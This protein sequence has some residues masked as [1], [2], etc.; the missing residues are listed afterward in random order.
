MLD[1]NQERIKSRA[2]STKI[3]AIYLTILVIIFGAILAGLVLDKLL[4]GTPRGGLEVNTKKVEALKSFMGTELLDLNE[5]I[6]RQLDISTTQGAL[7]NSVIDGSPADEAGMQRGDVIMQFDRQKV[8][9]TT[10]LQELIAETSPGDR[11]RV[12][13][14]R[15]KKTKAFYIKLEETPAAASPVSLTQAQPEEQ[16]PTQPGWGMGVAPISPDMGQ[17][18]GLQQGQEGILVTSIIPTGAA[19][20]AGI[21][22]GDVILAVNNQPTTG[23]SQFYEEIAGSQGVVLDIFRDEQS[24]Y[25]TV[26][27]NPSQLPTASLGM[28]TVLT[29]GSSEDDDEGYK[30]KPPVIPPK[31]EYDPETMGARTT[32][33]TL[34]SR[35]EVC[36]CPLCGTTVT[37]P[38]GT[39]CS[40]LKCP[41]CGSRLMNAS[42]GITTSFDD[43]RTPNQGDPQ[44]PSYAG[45]AKGQRDL[46]PTALSSILTGGGS[47]EDDDDEG[48]KPS[49]IPPMGNPGDAANVINIYQVAGKPISDQPS[50]IPSMG[51][52]TGGG[53]AVG[54]QTTAGTVN[55]VQVCICPVCGT[56]VGH[57]AGISCSD[58]NCPYCGSRMTSV[59]PG[60][61]FS[62]SQ[63]ETQQG[64][65]PPTAGQ[66]MA[67]G[68]SGGSSG[69]GNSS[70]GGPTADQGMAQGGTTGTQGMSQGSSSM[71]SS[72]YG[73]SGSGGPSGECVC[74][75]CGTLVSHAASVPCYAMKCPKC[76][77]PMVRAIP[78]VTIS[79][80]PETIP[81]TYK[82]QQTITTS[83]SISQKIAIASQGK[84]LSSKIAPL[85]DRSPYFV[86]VGL[87]ISEAFRNPNVNDSRDVGIQSAQFV[88]D[89]GA[90]AVITNNISLEA[91]Q[92]L[93]RLNIK[94]YS[95]VSGTVS[96]A[97]ECYMDGHLTETTLGTENSGSGSHE[98]SEGEGK[99]K[100][101][102]GRDAQKASM[103]I[104]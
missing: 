29:G 18:Y 24:S 76:G 49:T 69:T 59:D 10:H 70:S 86:I 74:P 65:R 95:G 41:I 1:K 2:G 88:V 56:T 9:D 33:G 97:L 73:S 85:F 99:S 81:P 27:A 102:L 23:L 34:N 30:G 54:A 50:D 7:I 44:R 71:G 31:G 21:Q 53:Q 38:A 61:N 25:T 51:K 64:N 93:R 67:Q 92:E 55:R 87:G 84:N 77:T 96:Q 98:E 83:G 43:T 47:S 16:T 90:G 63:G 100:N 104:L 28:S 52:P 78:G 26:Q 66:G 62:T 91:M 101:K 13:V 39:P 80:K 75:N 89:K 14:E 45:A 40:Q 8:R 6:K 17:R 79:D 48:H 4:K 3:W 82:G 46:N 94:V 58:L 72:R 42:P 37:H 35:I 103:V 32:A 12:A 57:P 11:V 60:A 15:D 36:V 20:A 68:G 19:S 22:V 5:V